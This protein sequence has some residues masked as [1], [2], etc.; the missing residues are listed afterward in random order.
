MKLSQHAGR[1]L[2]IAFERFGWPSWALKWAPW[3]LGLWM[4][5]KGEKVK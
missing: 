5:S 3:L 2:W 4:G 1:L